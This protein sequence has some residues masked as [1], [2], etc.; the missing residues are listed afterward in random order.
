MNIFNDYAR[1][2]DLIYRDK[3][4]AAESSYVNDLIQQHNPGATTLLNLGC[5]SGRHD[6]YL[7]SMGYSVTGV[8]I[9]DEMLSIARVGANG[10]DKLEYIKGDMGILRL[11][12]LFDAV[13]ALF[14]VICYQTTNEEILAAFTTACQHLNPGGIFIFDCWYGPGVLTDQPTTRIKE[15]ENDN[16][17]VTRIA[18]PVLHPNNNTVDVNYHIKIQDKETEMV[19]EIVELHKVR[20]LFLPEIYLLLKLAGMVMLDAHVSFQPEIKPTLGTWNLTVVSRPET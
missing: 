10:N 12:K 19:K 14:H 20:Y 11:G 7:A 6:S 2:Y 17:K 15:L 16:L 18:N 1:Y 13:T 4:Y 5:G 3:D 9:S 8:D